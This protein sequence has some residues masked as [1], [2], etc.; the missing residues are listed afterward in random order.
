MRR[1]VEDNRILEDFH[2]ELKKC[3][4]LVKEEEITLWKKYKTD[5]DLEA[6]D[7][8]LTSNYRLVYQLAELYKERGVPM[9][10][11]IQAGILG[12]LK[13]LD[14]FDGREGVRP[15]SY[16]VWWVK[17]KMLEE[18]KKRNGTVGE[19]MPMQSGDSPKDDDDMMPVGVQETSP[20]ACW[21]FE[22]A[23]TKDR[24][25]KELVSELLGRL[26]KSQRNVLELYF[27]IGSKDEKGMTLEEISKVRNSSKQAVH[28][29]YQHALQKLGAMLRQ[30][31]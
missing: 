4:P 16:C 10:D 30:G 11:L 23:I 8:I 9:A 19:D 13:G 14:K 1:Y 5:N 15:M 27:G 7:K 18:I 21:D 22:D 26:S 31:V 29:L 2:S 3:K 24:R 17:A 12:V 20:M 28:Q 6:R 25:M